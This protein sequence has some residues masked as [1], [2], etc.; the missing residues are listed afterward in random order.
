MDFN[1]D[2]LF[3]IIVELAQGGDISI[4]DIPDIE[5]YM[6]QVT[7]FMDNKLRYHKRTLKDKI[8]TKTMINNYTKSKILLP[9]KNKRYNRQHMILLILIYYL[10]QIL[11][12]NDISILFT[13][14]FNNMSSAQ[15]D[16]EYLGSL[17][18]SFLQL[19]EQGTSEL[20]DMLAGKLELIDSKADAFPEGSRETTRILLTVMMLVATASIQKS[21]AE[22]II[23][24]YLQ[25]K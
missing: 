10:K 15:D 9:S 19:K 8:L 20:K 2:S 22:K 17:Y 7:T 1:R 14:L 24:D 18:N 12:I 16:M 21:I 3:E 25:K 6:D 13:P 23:D 5:L 4:A 11:S